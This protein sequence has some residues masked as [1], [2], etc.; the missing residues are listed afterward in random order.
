MLVYTI[1]DVFGAL[2]LAVGIL[3]LALVW[4]I[5]KVIGWWKK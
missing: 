5:E 2:C 4:V 3:A 1:S